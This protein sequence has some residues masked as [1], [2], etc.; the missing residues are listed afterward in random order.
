[1]MGGKGRGPRL[2]VDALVIKD[3]MLLL[4][5][6]GREPFK[7]LHALPGGFVEEGETSEQAVLRE[8][9]E[10]TGVVAKVSRL[11]GVY[12]DPARD[13]RGH[14]VSVAYVLDYV[15]GQPVAGDDASAAEWVPLDRL[16]KRMAFDHSRIVADLR[17]SSC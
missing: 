2:T 17:S 10:E 11:H 14:T 4:V 3:R 7:G 5:R 15:S 6:R 9:L 12:S 13:P 1:M 8:L 16:P